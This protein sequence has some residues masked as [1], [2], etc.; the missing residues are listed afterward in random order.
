MTLEITEEAKSRAREVLSDL[1]AD[2]KRFYRRYGKHL[3]PAELFY[4]L[5]KHFGAKI[6]N[7]IS[8]PFGVSEGACILL[9][10]EIAKDSG[11]HNNTIN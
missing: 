6:A 1:A 7:R 3:S 10:I 2:L 8:I 5:E 9:A 11:D 4:E